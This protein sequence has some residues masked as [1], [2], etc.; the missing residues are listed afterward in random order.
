MVAPPIGEIHLRRQIEQLERQVQALRGMIL[1]AKM[2][3]DM[4]IYGEFKTH[5]QV[6]F[7][8]R[9]DDF[10]FRVEGDT[11]TDV[12]QVDASTEQ[13]IAGGFFNLKDAGEL[14]IAT[15]VV[16]A[17][18]SYH[19]I[20]TQNDDATDDLDTINGGNAGDILILRSADNARDPTV[21]DGT[22]NI[23][24]AGDFALSAIQDK[25]V[26]IK[27]GSNWHELSRSDNA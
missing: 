7:N 9:G 8:E 10:D 14:T 12:L 20:D 2:D 23:L 19:S 17:V 6:I 22:G 26:L 11:V 25:I 13:L 4:D 27:V 15:G 24:T 18:G 3:R 1:E 21:K 5:N 16:T